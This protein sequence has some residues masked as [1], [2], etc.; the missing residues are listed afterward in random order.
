MA[1]ECKTN[2]K[3][4]SN[5]PLRKAPRQVTS[6]EGLKNEGLGRTRGGEFYAEGAVLQRIHRHGGISGC[7]EYGRGER[8][9]A[10][11]QKVFPR[12]PSR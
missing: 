3:R 11:L 4:V 6:S 2:Q 8:A 1:E 5:P 12:F 10:R 7:P 9:E